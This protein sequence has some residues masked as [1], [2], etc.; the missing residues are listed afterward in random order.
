VTGT[1][2]VGAPV[3][4]YDTFDA[5]FNAGVRSLREDRASQAVAY[6]RRAHRIRPL[7]PEV[8][9]NLGYTYLKQKNYAAA[10]RSFR[11][12][13]DLRREQVNA[14]FGWAESLEALGDLEGA[15]G[16]MRTYMHL[17]PD[18]DPFK[19]RAMA[20]VWE[21]RETLRLKIAH[22]AK[23]ASQDVPLIGGGQAVDG[24]SRKPDSKGQA[25]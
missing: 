16:A 17:A 18:G 3:S 11:T 15:L 23:H 13:I 21:W 22:P 5:L 8:H 12:A 25:Q 10:E 4:G 1:A 2:P 9:V 24:N 20:A 7:V 14:Y 19:T 6:F